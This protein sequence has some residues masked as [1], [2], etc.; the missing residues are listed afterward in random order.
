MVQTGSKETDNLHNR[1]FLVT[2]ITL[3]RG[4]VV[5]QS[6]LLW[7]QNWRTNSHK[8]QQILWSVSTIVGICLPHPFIFCVFFFVCL[9]CYLIGAH[10]PVTVTLHSLSSLESPCGHCW[11]WLCH[12][13]SSTIIWLLIGPDFHYPTPRDVLFSVLGQLSYHWK[14]VPDMSFDIFVFGHVHHQEICSFHCFVNLIC[15]RNEN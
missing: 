14:Y 7:H 4:M 8:H 3:S 11:P 12:I 15:G 6:A 5:H 1:T 9:I 13:W 2:Q 10:I